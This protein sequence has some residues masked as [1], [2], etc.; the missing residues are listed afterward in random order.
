MHGYRGEKSDVWDVD[1]AL[2]IRVDVSCST[3]AGADEA[4]RRRSRWVVGDRTRDLASALDRISQRVP[5]PR[6]GLLGF[7]MRGVLA[8]LGGAD[9]RVRA[10]VADSAFP[11]QRAV[12]VHAAESDARRLFRGLVPG[13]AFL[14]AMEWWHRRS[15]K[16]PFD[17][18]APVE[19][20]GDLA[21]T[22][23]LF[24]H[25][26]QDHWIPRLAAA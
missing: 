9:P 26:D 6:L 4:R 21:G 17:A 1:R 12:L 11:S 16:P 5:D 19:R 25:G 2:A 3:S 7:S 23:L 22:P 18:I 24:I 20:V 15:G 8:I 13:R 14:P 10:I